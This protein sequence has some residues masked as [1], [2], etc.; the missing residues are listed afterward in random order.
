MAVTNKEVR[1][2]GKVW[3]GRIMDDVEKGSGLEVKL[4]AVSVLALM[5]KGQKVS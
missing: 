1:L 2:H 3:N 4:V 5:K